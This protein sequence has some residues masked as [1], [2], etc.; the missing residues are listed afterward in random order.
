MSDGRIFTGRQALE[1]NLIDEIGGNRE[2]KF[3]LIENREINTD[4]EILIYDQN[5]SLIL[6]N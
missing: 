3:W 2:A 5:K 6:L 1:L 4:L